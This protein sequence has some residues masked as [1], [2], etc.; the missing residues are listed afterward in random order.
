MEP[1]WGNSR[2]ELNR[3]TS[4]KEE[5]ELKWIFLKKQENLVK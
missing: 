4:Q 1:K 5:G 2:G 3:K